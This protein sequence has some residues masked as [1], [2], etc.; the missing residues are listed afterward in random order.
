MAAQNPAETP[1]TNTDRRGFFRRIGSWFMGLGLIAG[2][3]TFAALVVRFLFPTRGIRKVWLFVENLDRVSVGD[4]IAYQTP[5]GQ[6][7]LITRVGKGDDVEDFIALSSVCPHLGCQVHWEAQNDRFFCP[8]HNG[9]FD[10]EG[11]ATEGPPKDAGQTLARYPLKVKK[12]MLFIEVE[13]K[14]LIPRT[15]RERREN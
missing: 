3:G 7:V 5:V 1:D 11:N 12:G 6:Q 9:A 10:A 14:P 15:E 13:T 4:S 8:C 2:Y